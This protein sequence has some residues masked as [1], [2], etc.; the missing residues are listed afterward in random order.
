MKIGFIGLGTMGSPMAINLV[1]AGFDVTVH[2]R[3]SSR[4][5]ALV[6]SGATSALTPAGAAQNADVVITIVSDTPDVESVIF[7]PDGVG[8]TV[9]AGAVVVDM[10]TISPS[11]TREFGERLQ[12]QG[13]DFVDAPV[14]GGSEGAINA[15]LTIMAGGTPQ[16]VERVMPVLQVLGS[17]VTHMGPLGSGQATKAVNQVIGAGVYLAVAEGMALGMASGLDMDLVLAAVGAGASR[18]WILENRGRNMVDSNFPL[19]FRMALHRKDLSIAL[20][21][22]RS[23][24]LDL[25][26]AR[27]VAD[28]EDALISQ[29]CGDEDLSAVARIYEAGRTVRPQAGQ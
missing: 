24:G 18:S 25:Q 12:G 29:G 9:R 11:A 7:G 17:R 22:A 28:V 27:M 19:G 20:E 8:Q 21:S 14:S 5:D 4:V 3:T 13:V 26:L 15:T 16:A 10:S 23:V 1:R 6:Q 2:N